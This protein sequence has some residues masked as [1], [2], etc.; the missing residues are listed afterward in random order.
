MSP[1]SARCI[2]D[3]AQS[4]ISEV[5]YNGKNSVVVSITAQSINDIDITLVIITFMNNDSVNDHSVR[6]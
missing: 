1:H 4:I 5:A 3:L 6:I 2:S